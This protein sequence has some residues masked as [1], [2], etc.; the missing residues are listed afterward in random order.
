MLGSVLGEL[1]SGFFVVGRKSNLGELLSG[2]QRGV[3]GEEVEGF[4]HVISGSLIS[5]D[6]GGGIVFYFNLGF[7]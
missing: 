4:I 1:G 6:D 2:G 5:V 7:K 3:S